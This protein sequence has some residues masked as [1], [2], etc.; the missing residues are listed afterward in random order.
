MK[1]KITIIGMAASCFVVCCTALCFLSAKSQNPTI[2]KLLSQNVQA[3]AKTETSNP[4]PDPYDVPNRYIQVSTTTEEV[5]SDMEGN[6][7]IWDKVFGGYKKNKKYT[8]VIVTKNCSGEA[9]G[10]CCKQSEVGATI[11]IVEL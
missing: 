2:V 7:S 6:I 11:E 9:E 10:A 1:R 8:V 3:L 4:C 5:T